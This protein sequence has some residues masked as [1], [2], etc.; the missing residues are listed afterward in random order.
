MGQLGRWLAS[1]G[2]EPAQL[3]DVVIKKF[4]ADRRAEGF[5]RIATARSFAQLIKHLRAEG[6]VSARSPEVRVAPV[7]D[8]MASYKQ[9]LMTDRALA[10]STVLRY[11]ALAR[12]FLQ[13]R[14]T[15]CGELGLD[16]LN[17]ADVARF[18]LGECARLSVGSAKGRVTELRSLLRFLH[19]KGLTALS[20]AESVPPVAGW[21]DTGVPKAMP[22]ADIEA[23]LQSCDR[24]TLAGTRDFAMVTLLARLGL[25]SAEVASLEV[26]DL[27]WRAGEL[28]VRGKARRQDRLPLPHDVG[29]AVVAYLSLRRSVGT[30]RVFLTLRPPH[31]PVLPGLVGEVV[32]RACRRSGLPVVGAHRLRH[33]LATELLRQG[34]SLVDISQVLRH[35]DLATTAVYAKVDL[36][37]LRQVA[38]PWPGAAR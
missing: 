31:R 9:W 2:V 13:G 12:V 16:G 8:L 36:S 26:A 6:V 27:D 22:V 17:G 35:R 11:E 28:I 38:R 4:L 20:L 10:P 7:G 5:K 3:D 33:T 23:L 18:L 25:R 30:R 32:Q 21:R 14:A 24:S 29:E 37:R 15:S 34:A 19:L 1:R